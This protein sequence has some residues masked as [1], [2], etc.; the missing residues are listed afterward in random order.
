MDPTLKFFGEHVLPVLA[1]IQ[2]WQQFNEDVRRQALGT[3]LHSVAQEFRLM[4]PEH[5]SQVLDIL[6]LSDAEKMKLG[7]GILSSKMVHDVPQTKQ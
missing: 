3:I 1:E 7:T 5:L 2:S 6:N 4:S